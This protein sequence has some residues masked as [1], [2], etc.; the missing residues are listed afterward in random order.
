[1][2]GQLQLLSQLGFALALG[3]MMDTFVIRPLLLPAF[4]SL[5]GRTGKAPR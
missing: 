3:M 1:M 2:A 4:A 5:T